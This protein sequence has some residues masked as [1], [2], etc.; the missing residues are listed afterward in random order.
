MCYLS[1]P[2]LEL[3]FFEAISENPSFARILAFTLRSALKMACPSSPARRRHY[4][5]ASSVTKACLR[6]KCVENAMAK[7]SCLPDFR[8]NTEPIGKRS[9]YVSLRNPLPMDLLR[10]DHSARSQGLCA[11]FERSHFPRPNPH[12]SQVRKRRRRFSSPDRKG[13]L[14]PRQSGDCAVLENRDAR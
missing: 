13:D 14:S 12:A 10:G 1:L 9:Y 11:G 6:L 8:G 4:S 2:R 5:L 3:F 7:Y